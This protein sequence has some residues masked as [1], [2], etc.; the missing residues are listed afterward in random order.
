MAEG[1]L[2]ADLAAET[3][4]PRAATAVVRLGATRGVRL[5]LDDCWQLYVS[6]G[7]DAPFVRNQ[8][9]VTRHGGRGEIAVTTPRERRQVL[10]ALGGGRLSDGLRSL[11][12]ALEQL[13]REH[14]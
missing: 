8:L 3:L 2:P 1:L 7:E 6:L 4:A 10:D 13:P 11:R 12:S 5:S 9:S 14:R